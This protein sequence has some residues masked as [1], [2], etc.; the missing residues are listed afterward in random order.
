[1]NTILT[2]SI[3]AC[4]F[5]GLLPVPS[6]MGGTY[7]FN[8]SDGVWGDPEN[9]IPD[10]NYPGQGDTA[11]I[12]ANQTCRIENADQYIAVLEIRS[13]GVLRIKGKQLVIYEATGVTWDIDG[14]LI[15]ELVGDTSAYII[16]NNDLTI[17]GDGTIEAHDASSRLDYWALQFHA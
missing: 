16:V 13:G 17:L 11:I 14:E 6:L 7:T 15:G 2:R 3:C 4:L 1:M 9:W 5:L 10:T 12:L 8:V